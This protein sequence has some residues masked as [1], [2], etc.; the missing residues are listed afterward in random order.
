MISLDVRK[1]DS[2]KCSVAMVCTM[3]SFYSKFTAIR[4]LAKC[5]SYSD[6]NEMSI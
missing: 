4:R 2:E 6:P 1:I 3:N 5:K